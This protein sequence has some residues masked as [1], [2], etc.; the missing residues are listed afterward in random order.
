MSN[1][2]ART[3]AWLSSR[4]HG[5]FS[6]E[7]MTVLRQDSRSRTKLRKAASPGG[8]MVFYPDPSLSREERK[9]LWPEWLRDFRAGNL[10][11]QFHFSAPVQTGRKAARG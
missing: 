5:G 3:N 1:K 7:S 2:S 8:A 4:R 6:G 9:K 11:L 10:D